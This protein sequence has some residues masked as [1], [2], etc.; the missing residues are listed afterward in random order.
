MIVRVRAG[1]VVPVAAPVLRD[2]WIDVDAARGEIVGVGA[3]IGAEPTT[4][5]RASSTCR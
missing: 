1:W 5:R 2:G 3:A 4:R